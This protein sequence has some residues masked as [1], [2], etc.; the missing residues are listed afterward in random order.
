MREGQ[1][2]PVAEL[3]FRTNLPH[4]RVYLTGFGSREQR[5]EAGDELG[6]HHSSPDKNTCPSYGNGKGSK[7]I[8][9][10]TSLTG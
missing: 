7:D 3:L 2:Y 8:S 1:S 10:T 5:A 9:E 6:D 4:I